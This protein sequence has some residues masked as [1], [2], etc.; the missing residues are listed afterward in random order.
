MKNPQFSKT[1]EVAKAAGKKVVVETAESATHAYKKQF[2]LAVVAV[3][4][5]GIAI[6]HHF[7]VDVQGIVA[8]TGL[9]ME[10]VA[11]AVVGGV[12]AIANVVD[13]KFGSKPVDQ[14]DRITPR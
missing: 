6:G 7:G 13:R 4:A 1:I 8:S 3:G 2:P 9:S 11:A 10:T 12:L 14:Q 5:A